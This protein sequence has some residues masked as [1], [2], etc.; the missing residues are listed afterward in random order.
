MTKLGWEGDDAVHVPPTRWWRG[1]QGHVPWGPSSQPG[2]GGHAGSGTLTACSLASP[3]RDRDPTASAEGPRGCL[4]SWDPA[5]RRNQL[6]GLGLPCSERTRRRECVEESFEYLKNVQGEKSFPWVGEGGGEEEQGESALPAEPRPMTAVPQRRV[7]G[8]G[9]AQSVHGLPGS[10][11]RRRYMQGVC[12]LRPF[13]EDIKQRALEN[14]HV[15][16]SAQRS[17]TDSNGPKPATPWRANLT[18]IVSF[19]VCVLLIKI[20]YICWLQY[21]SL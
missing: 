11:R 14:L 18:W 3:A 21:Q 1:T 2:T 17:V 5:L 15:C 7:R 13:D 19:L 6:T 8:R 4:S 16:C 10:S 9:G 20:E 12:F